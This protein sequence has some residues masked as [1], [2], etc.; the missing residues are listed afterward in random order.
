MTP[1]AVTVGAHADR[2]AEEAR[3]KA[4]KW[5]LPFLERP[6]KGGVAALLSGSARACLVRSADGWALRDA[7]GSL[8]FTPGIAQLRLKRLAKGHR[9]DVLL[10]LS[11]LRPGDSVLD[12]T[13]G[14]AADALVCARA[15]GPSGR[16]LG[17][18]AAL[19]LWILVS[20]G[21]ARLPV[22]PGSSR[23][24]LVHGRAR[25]V[26]KGQAS[27][28]V[29]VVLFDP[30]FDR[31]RRSSPSFELLRAHALHEPLDEETLAQARRVARRWVVLKAGRY[32]KDF[33]RLGLRAMELG[34]AGPVMWTR[35]E[36]A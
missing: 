6:A 31:P 13:A 35:V 14:L 24:E 34:R 32:G 7:Q 5:G 17:V 9:D 18:E 8:A 12:A 16:V 4:A 2:F 19:P 22:D 1:L 20:E 28:S 10:R 29:D 3:R 27:R 30:M 23:I 33:R 25:D 15:V 26:L 21:L 11:E 36:P